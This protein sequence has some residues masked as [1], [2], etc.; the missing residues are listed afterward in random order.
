M[1]GRP[2]PHIPSQGHGLSTATP[3]RPRLGD[4]AADSPKGGRVGVVV[5]LPGQ[6]VTTTYHLSPPG[7]GDHWSA[8][9]DGSTLRP[10]PTTVTHATLVTRDAVYDRRARQGSL[11]ILVHHEDGGSTE[12]TLVLT[13]PDMERLHA[14]A[15]RILVERERALGGSP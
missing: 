11:A 10:V 13:P 3:F 7:G 8:P 1:T 9:G 2:T 15:A 12:S 4:L 5:A 6:G 14:Q